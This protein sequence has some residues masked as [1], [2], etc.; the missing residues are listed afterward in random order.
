LRE[1]LN[2]GASC[3]EPVPRWPGGEDFQRVGQT[4][5]AAFVQFGVGPLSGAYRRRSQ[6]ADGGKDCPHH[7]ARDGDLGELEADVPGMA[8]NASADF[9]RFQLQAG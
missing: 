1:R 6:L 2:A 5:P 8:D 3:F 7:R 4:C 9:D